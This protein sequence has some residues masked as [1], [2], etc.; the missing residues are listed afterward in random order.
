MP[1]WSQTILNFGEIRGNLCIVVEGLK[2]TVFF[3]PRK[4]DLDT[5]FGLDWQAK[6]FLDETF[7]PDVGRVALIVESLQNG[8]LCTSM[9]T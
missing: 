3:K 7:K 4:E 5:N 9:F 6:D 8:S 1:K 2:G